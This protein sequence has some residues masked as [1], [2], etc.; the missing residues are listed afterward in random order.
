M[1]QLNENIEKIEKGSALDKLYNRLLDG[2]QAAQN[3]GDLPDFTS[4]EYI[5]QSTDESGNIVY[6]ANED[7]INECVKSNQEISLKNAAYLIASSIAGDSGGGSSAEGGLYVAL[8]GDVMT[9]TLSTPYGFKAGDNGVSFFQI[10]QTAESEEVES[11]NIVKV[12]GELHLPDNGLYI[13]ETNVLSYS[14]DTSIL[15]GPNIK[16]DGKV[17]VSDSLSIGDF[18]I[19]KDGLSFSDGRVYYHSGNSNKSDVDWVMKNGTIYGNLL[20]YGA[21]TLKSTITAL[22]GA[23]LGYNNKEILGLSGDGF[24][25]LYGDLAIH[26]GGI[27]YDGEYIIYIK[28]DNVVAFSAANKILNLGDNNTQKISLQSGVYNDNSDYQ[29]VSKF[30]DGY[31]PNSFKAGH[32]LSAPLIK[33]YSSTSDDIGIIATRYLRFGSESGCAFY[34]EGNILY[35]E[36]PFVYNETSGDSTVT[37]TQNKK[38]GLSYGKSESQL[39]GKSGVKSSFSFS[40]EADLYSFDSPVEGK[41]YVGIADSTTALYEKR[42]FFDTSVY[43]QGI[44]DGVK[45]YGNAYIVNDIGSVEFSSGFAGSGW[46]ILENQLTGNVGATFDELTIR[47]K[48]RVYE[49]EVQKLSVTNGSLWV[50]DACSGDIVEEV[51]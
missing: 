10:Y 3:E 5:T 8:T 40:T 15:S 44:E 4:D 25:D 29:L 32:S 12:S 46:K 6:T 28:N 34:G 7:K 38:T 41:I 20:V 30:G 19:G 13:N 47:K 31:F 21:S 51:A 23:S 2:F 1:A 50:S 24:V 49:L 9:G 14:N 43:W 17:A 37:V 11:K 48:M 33:T 22:G 45:H 27:K 18:T 26:S 16:L 36:G 42:L 39:I 35:F